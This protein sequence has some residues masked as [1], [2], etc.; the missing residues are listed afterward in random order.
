MAVLTPVNAGQEPT[1]HDF[2]A[3][4]VAAAA[5]GDTFQNAGKTGFFVVNSSGGP[6]TVTFAAVGLCSH[7]QLHPAAVIVPDGHSDFIATEFDSTRFNDPN[8]DIAVTYSSEVGIA[9]IPVRLSG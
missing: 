5:G 9:V 7:G 6:E 8:G 2:A 3:Q 4:T 1:P